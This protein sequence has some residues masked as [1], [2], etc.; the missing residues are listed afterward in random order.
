[1]IMKRGSCRI[2]RKRIV[3]MKP[4]L[5][6]SIYV[7][8]LGSSLYTSALSVSTVGATRPR[9]SHS[10]NYMWTQVVN[11]RVTWI[12]Q[13]TMYLRKTTLF[14]C[15]VF[16]T[17][18]CISKTS[19][20]CPLLNKAVV[21]VVLSCEW[22]TEPF[23]VKVSTQRE[24][25]SGL[26]CGLRSTAKL[27]WA[28][29]QNSAEARE[30]QPR[31][32]EHIVWTETPTWNINDSCTNSNALVFAGQSACWEMPYFDMSFTAALSREVRGRDTCCNKAHRTKLR[33]DS[34]KE[35]WEK[36]RKGC[37]SHSDVTW[38]YE[39]VVFKKDFLWP[40]HWTTLIRQKVSLQ[41]GWYTS[42]SY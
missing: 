35:R 28:A 8:S 37:S 33:R 23:K 9:N 29:I 26:S 42:A 20:S 3:D 38:K 6:L 10:I 5:H 12:S 25:I 14:C 22:E 7:V 4:G 19:S 15:C 16:F 40:T 21:L 30:V 13:V 34:T 36:R 31:R 18:F 24:M 39:V 11:S 32:Q 17:L 27:R 41:F 1:M 2:W